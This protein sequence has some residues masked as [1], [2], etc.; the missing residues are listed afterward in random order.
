MNSLRTISSVT[1]TGDVGF[2]QLLLVDEVVGQ[3]GW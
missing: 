1:G 2:L 3:H